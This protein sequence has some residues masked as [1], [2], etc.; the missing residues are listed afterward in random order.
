MDKPYYEYLTV[1][2][3]GSCTKNGKRDAKAGIGICFVLKEFP[4]VS[5]L[6]NN[7]RNTNQRAELYAIQKAIE[8]VDQGCRFDKLYIYTDSLYSIKCLT[9]WID[10]WKK[11]NWK[12]TTGSDIVNLDIIQPIDLLLTKHHAKIEFRHVK[13]HTTDDTFEAIYNR[14]A[15]KLATFYT[16][17]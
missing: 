4:N 3:D 9:V 14:K 2:T 1:F 16:K 10:N 8:I 11:N 15:D 6:L 17:N 13:A 5:E 12:S 7:G